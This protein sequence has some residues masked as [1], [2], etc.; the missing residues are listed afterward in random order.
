MAVMLPIHRKEDATFCNNYKGI[1]LVSIAGK[2]Y[3]HPLETRPG[4]FGVKARRDSQDWIF[5]LLQITECG[6]DLR[7]AF[8]TLP[9]SNKWMPLGNRGI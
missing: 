4:G 7:K 9:N 5:K 2:F 8:D 3:D 1:S 6:V